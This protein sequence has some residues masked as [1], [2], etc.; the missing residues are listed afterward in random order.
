MGPSLLEEQRRH[1]TWRRIALV[2]LVA[3]VGVAAL[4][5]GVA[6]LG[7]GIAGPADDQPVATHAPALPLGP[8]EP[9]TLAHV[10]AEGMEQP[11]RL[12]L[13]VRRRGITAIGYAHR[14]APELL[15][16]AP[17][18]SRANPAFAQRLLG[19]FLATRQP[20][21]LRWYELSE[22]GKHNTVTV[23]AVPGTDVYA[24]LAGTVIAIADDVV[25]GHRHGSVVHLQPLGDGE[26][27]ITLRGIEAAPAL[28]V[29]LTV[30]EGASVVGYVSEQRG[31]GAPLARFSHD[32][33]SGVELA[34]WR[35]QAERL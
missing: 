7:R 24:P 18:G 27:V 19:R 20:S 23:G 15:P 5:W 31:S 1:R 4:V 16:L 25:N 14:S 11:L 22:G 28:A 29:G 33:G 26:T 3:V 2:A 30:S 13:P 6:M 10:P 21:G 9:L 8:P 32:S 35:T 17:E 34:V 12:R